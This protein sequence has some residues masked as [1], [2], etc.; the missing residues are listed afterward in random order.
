MSNRIGQVLVGAL[1]F[2]LVG[3]I[4]FMAVPKRSMALD[5]KKPAEA[6]QDAPEL[7]GGVAWLNTAGPIKLKDIKGKVVL[8]DFWTLCCINCIHVMPDLAKLEKKYPNELVVIGVH[9][10][11]FENEKDT[12]SIK[13]AVLRYELAHP[14]VN[15]ANHKIWNAYGVESWPTIALIDPEGKFVG[16]AS[17]EGNYEVLDKIIGKLVEE[18]KAKGTLDAKPI[19][20]DLIRYRETADTPLFFPGKVFADEKG[21]R[22][23]IADSTHHRIVVTNLAGEKKAIIGS[24]TPGFKNGPAAEA[25]FDDPQG[26]A[27]DGET[28]YVADRK[29]HSI[30]SVDLKAMTVATAAGTGKQDG[31]F[32]LR[33]LTT[34]VDA[35]KIG[36]NSPWDILI[37]GREM[38]IAMAGHHQIW[39]MDLDAKKLKPFAG[40]GRENIKDGPLYA[41]NFAQPSGL[42]TDGVNLYVADSEVSAIRKLP[43]SGEGRVSTIVGEGLFEFGDIDGIGDKARIQHALGVIVVD[44]KLIVADTYNSKLKKLDPATRACSTWLG[45]SKAK[46]PLFNEPAGLTTAKGKIYVA[47]TNANR[48]QVVDIK[49]G[50]VSTLPLKGVEPPPPQKEWVKPEAKK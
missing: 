22:L 35:K 49:T 12:K 34:F 15:D 18:H 30:R 36:L 40:T 6:K 27:L 3:G 7:D 33:K 13:Q 44:G 10:A 50:A 16:V 5:D 20:F 37:Q 17:G 47:D 46:E 9:S 1:I 41:A 48:I 23:F 45:D 31:D 14:V 26:M 42:A 43:L 24:G 2:T 21:D 4:A 29:N 39:V 25:Q 19:R 11:K 28:L 32:D 38:F 8:L